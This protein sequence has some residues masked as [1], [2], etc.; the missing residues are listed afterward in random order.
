MEPIASIDFNFPCLLLEVVMQKVV[1][2]LGSSLV[3]IE[4]EWFKLAFVWKIYANYFNIIVLNIYGCLNSWIV[5]TVIQY[6]GS[7]KY[8]LSCYFYINYL[9]SE[10]HLKSF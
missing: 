4:N 2:I 3:E 7:N 10:I 9:N 1:K 8:L 6:V 5:I